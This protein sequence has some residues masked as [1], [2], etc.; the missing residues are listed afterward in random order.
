M[1]HQIGAALRDESFY[2]QAITA[3]SGPAMVNFTSLPIARPASATFAYAMLAGRTQ[4]TIPDAADEVF[5]SAPVLLGA[6]ADE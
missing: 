6:W 2:T 4:D 1:P 3:A 5:V